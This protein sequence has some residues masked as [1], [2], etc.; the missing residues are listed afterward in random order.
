VV[1]VKLDEVFKRLLDSQKF[2]L[3]PVPEPREEDQGDELSASDYAEMLGWNVSFDLDHS[4]N[5]ED[6]SLLPILL[7]P[8]NLESLTRKIGSAAKTAIEE[9]GTNMLYL[10][11]GFLEWYE[12]NN[13]EQPR[14]APIIT[15]PVTLERG[16][17]K[18]GGFE[19]TIEYSGEDCSENLSLAER[20]RR[21]FGIDLPSFE[22]DDNLESYFSRLEPILAQRRRWRIRRHL[23]L[24]LL[25]FGKL[26]MFRDL[27]PKNWPDIL[28]HPLVKELFEGTKSEIIHAEEFLIDD[29][30]LK[31]QVPNLILD[32]DS[33][34]HSALIH[35]LRGDNL[36]IEGPPGTGKSQTITNLIAAALERGKT[37]LFVAEKLAALEV[38][39]RRLDG[40]GLG[41]FC[42]EL[43]SHKTKKH[44]LLSELE[45]RLK[46]RGS[47][48]EP[49]ELTQHLAIVEEKKKHL[50]NYAGLLN[51]QIEPFGITLH[52]ILWARERFYQELPFDGEIRGNVPNVYQYT[53]ADFSAKEQLLATFA[54]HLAIILSQAETVETHPWNWVSR[55]I[56]LTEEENLCDLLKA[57]ISVLESTERTLSSIAV[58]GIEPVSACHVA[59]GGL[60][61]FVS[62]LPEIPI[63][64]NTALVHHCRDSKG[65]AELQ[66]FAGAVECASLC[67]QQL[68]KAFSDPEKLLHTDA[69]NALKHA[70]SLLDTLSKRDENLEA[71]R[72][73]ASE[74]ENAAQKLLNAL[75]ALCAIEELLG[76]KQSV[77]AAR[78]ALLI[79]F[80]Q[81]LEDAPQESLYLRSEQ[82]KTEAAWRVVESAASESNVL[83]QKVQEI[84]GFDQPLDPGGITLFSGFVQMLEHAPKESLHLRS[85][86]IKADAARRAVE[87]AALESRDL[88][89]KCDK[90]N[91]EYDVAEA[92]LTSSPED[93]HACAQVIEA[94]GFFQRWFGKDFRRA[95][96]VHQRLYRAGNKAPR[97][98]MAR[99]FRELAD[100]LSAKARFANRPDLKEVIGATFRGTS[101]D[102]G[103][104]LALTSWYESV[105]TILPEHIAT[106]AQY[107][108]MLF[109]GRIERLKGLVANVNEHADVLTSVVQF[110]DREELKRLLGAAFKGTRTDW[111]ALLALISWYES[112]FAVF[113][114]HLF[115]AD[116]YRE[117]LLGG[118]TERLKG[119]RAGVK[120]HAAQAAILR[121]IHPL[122]VRASDLLGLADRDSRTLQELIDRISSEQA[123]IHAVIAQLEVGGLLPA[124]PL[125]SIPEWI[126]VASRYQAS[127]AIAMKS[128]SVREV[129]AE[130]DKG[131]STDTSVIRTALAFVDCVLGSGL[132]S[133]AIAELLSSECAEKIHTLSAALK[134]LAVRGSELERLSASIDS[135]SGSSLWTIGTVPFAQMLDKAKGAHRA[136]AELRDWMHYVAVRREVTEAGLEKLA[137]LAVS[138]KIQP[139]HLVPA[140]RYLFYNSF[141]HNLLSENPELYRLSGL[142]HEQTRRDFQESDK[143]AIRL[144]SRRVASVLD[145]RTV[146]HGHHS[147]PVKNWTD[148]ALIVHEINKQKR[149]IPIRQLVR[150]AGSAL[151]GLKPCFMMGPLSVAQY[152]PPNH[153]KFDLIVMDEASQLRPE[154][155]IGAIAR[156]GQLVVVGDP[157]QLPPTSFFQR[158]LADEEVNGDD[159]TAIVEEGE[160][161]LDVASTLYQPVRRL[162]WHYRSRHHSLIAFS[163]RE[164]Y[165]DDLVI[166]PTAFDEHP[167]LGVKYH[168][169]LTGVFDSRRNAPEADTVVRAVLAHMRQHPAESLGVVALNLE[170]RDLIE[171]LLDSKLRTDP[172]ALKYQ[173]TMSNGAEPFF[174]KNLENVQ[175]DERDVI[176]ISVTYGPD[177]Q[178]NLYQR[179]GPINGPHG[180]RRLNVLFTRA[181][182]RTEVFSSLNPDKIHTTENS[183][184]G[185]RALRE[186]LSFAR[187]GI[188]ASADENT[189]Q[190]RNDFE[191]SVGA[192]LKARGYTVAPQVGVAG[193]FID[194]AVRHP[195]KPGK[196]LLGVECDGASYHSGRSAR[197]RDRLREEILVNLGWRIHRIWST[198]WFKNRER[199]IEKLLQKLQDLLAV[200]PEYRAEQ[201]RKQQ[202][203]NLRERFEALREEIR[204]SFPETPPERRLLREELMEEFLRKRPKIREQWFKMFPMEVRSRTES[205]EVAKFLDR[206]LELCAEE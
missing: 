72:N 78:V 201:A 130:H 164:F 55:P 36:V 198:D 88:T 43:H 177:S 167:E 66:E 61:R 202:V 14:L 84:L 132:P 101:T 95:A 13:S 139:A 169:V 119:L 120:E 136:S 131:P 178:G 93:L 128:D 19:C 148:L 70:L 144:Q 27:D 30:K 60:T 187:S 183:P 185:L 151:R 142:T 46:A 162:R 109:E 29:Q 135:L 102:W 64:L 73:R 85:E 53:R 173:E 2:T 165:G 145:R 41:M 179:F 192:A 6:P 50:T 54:Q 96:R 170:Q 200:D 182:R 157:M 174:V 52:E 159:N 32:A 22:E 197:D 28:I 134:D 7:Y 79:A 171:E 71:L 206:V 175:G 123:V 190:P 67:H 74:L 199:E 5:F 49:H 62:I 137:G 160:S 126:D 100:L 17:G 98:A 117:V 39:R 82:I 138:R 193:F 94:S 56:S 21:D 76:F 9:S 83:C 153:L 161:I 38:V 156:G 195:S 143:E 163:N 127:T 86:R 69:V 105:F 203:A 176:F 133:K 25:S 114:E 108:E 4:A 110:T 12:D 112:I 121:S 33:S 180:H 118:R 34:Q 149:H 107:R 20:M 154:D 124:E 87:T 75:P 90:L 42:L 24:C 18:R 189:L 116:E 172:F 204:R 103:K 31:P 80:V 155:A 16:G 141:A 158:G 15:V 152:L 166:F 104:L 48:S 125:G 63:G 59:L 188:L 40:A 115:I 45:T 68:Q 111:A 65:R 77:D 26:L 99:G 196:F 23:T 184:W 11:F 1:G 3:C 81:L 181:K 91:E 47:F 106:A 113:P 191:R 194:L 35:A 58:F 37:V 97:P 168:P 129:L 57:L 8:S 89:N 10:V 140:F 92:A 51:R 147:G 150:R 205:S 122:A 146:P 186:Y 44:A